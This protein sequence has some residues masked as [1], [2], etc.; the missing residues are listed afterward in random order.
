MNPL[1]IGTYS[2]VKFS[3][4]YTTLIEKYPKGMLKIITISP[5]MKYHTCFYTNYFPINKF[6][7]KRVNPFQSQRSYL[8]NKFIYN[9]LIH[10]QLVRK[11]L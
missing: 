7:N 6:Y 4:E 8:F 1:N 2:P 5:N 3:L 9:P 10:V 11:Q